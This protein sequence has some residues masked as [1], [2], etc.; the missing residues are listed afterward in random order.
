MYIDFRCR[1]FTLC[2]YIYI[3]S[4]LK[5]LNVLNKTVA[6]NLCMKQM[7][8]WIRIHVMQTNAQPINAW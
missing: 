8:R 4:V 2:S 3:T 1:Q 5:F 6:M 7:C